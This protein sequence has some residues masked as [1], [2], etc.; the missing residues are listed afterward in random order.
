MAQK[1]SYSKNWQFIIFLFFLSSI[2]GFS[3]ALFETGSAYQE[4]FDIATEFQVDK[5]LHIEII[6]INAYDGTPIKGV[7]M[8]SDDNWNK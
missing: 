4:G 6:R 7:L 1:N 3:Y 8:S 2:V 5:D